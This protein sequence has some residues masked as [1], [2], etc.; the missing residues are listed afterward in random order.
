MSRPNVGSIMISKSENADV[1]RLLNDRAQSLSAAVV[2]LLTSSAGSRSWRVV[3]TG[4]ACF[5]KDWNRKGFFIQVNL[6]LGIL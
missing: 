4:V 1:F 3:V 2:Q 6:V 5:V